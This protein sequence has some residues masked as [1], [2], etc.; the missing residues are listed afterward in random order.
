METITKSATETQ[1]LGQKI[2]SSLKGGE[3]VALI[4]NLGVGK[5]TF[6]QGLVKGLG[7]SARI[8]SPTFILMRKYGKSF[9]HLDLYRLESDVWNEVKNLGVTDLWGRDNI[10]VIEWAEKIKDHLP[11][12]T[13]W[14]NLEQVGDNERRILVN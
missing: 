8:I 13:I 2:G 5:T 9:Y 10:F 14:I 7:L 6:V 3:V 12:G 1:S 4:G 11:K